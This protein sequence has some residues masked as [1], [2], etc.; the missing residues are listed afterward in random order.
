MFPNVKNEAASGVTAGNHKATPLDWLILVLVLAFIAAFHTAAMQDRLLLILYAI[1][2]S[3]A[4]FALLRRHAFVMSV[5]TLTSAATALL[6]NVYF[7]TE[8]EV[9]H[10]ILDPV[11]D[12]LGLGMLAFVMAKLVFV[13]YRIQKESRDAEMRRVY[14]EKLVS[15]RA[16]ALRSTSHEVR[17]P[18]ST[19]LAINETLLSECA[20]PLNEVQRDF[21]NDIDSS[22]RHLMGLVNDILDYAKAEAGM[23]ELSPEPVALSELVDQCIKMVDPKAEEARVSVTAQL[24]PDIKEIVADPLRLKQIVINLLTNAIKYNEPG[25]VVNVRA[26]QDGDML[27]LSVR[28]TGRGIKAEDMEHLFNPY[29]QAARKDQGIGTGLGLAII[30]HLTELHG[31]TITVESVEGSGSVFT[32][33]LPREAE[34]ERRLVNGPLV[35]S[36]APLADACGSGEES[37]EAEFQTSV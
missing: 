35:K 19:I 36:D 23:I 29:F 12:V 27:L 18:L 37:V 21:L 14:E 28:D 25:G 6:V 5:I 16:A 32:V 13:S 26:R 1:G 33:R 8:T 30:K 10:P 11:R 9:C 2:I 24:A 17:T 34:V 31:G 7:Q 3:G 22:S 4:T 20:G 15:M